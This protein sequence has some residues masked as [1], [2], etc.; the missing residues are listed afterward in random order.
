MSYLRRPETLTAAVLELDTA[1][2]RR[3]GGHSPEARSTGA[4]ENVRAL[5]RRRP[6][7]VDEGA[8]ERGHTARP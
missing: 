6:P 8:A 2:R 4:A 5:L 1:F 7:V 3:N